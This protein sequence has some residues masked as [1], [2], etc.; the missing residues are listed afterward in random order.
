[1]KLIFIINN[2][3]V[4]SNSKRKVEYSYKN[5]I[6]MISL[7]SAIHKLTAS[8]IQNNQNKSDPI[9]TSFKP[10]FVH[11]VELYFKIFWVT[12]HTSNSP[13]RKNH[14]LLIANT[15]RHILA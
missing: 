2:V 8:A 10:D 4:V 7:Q 3:G 12:D 14:G 1:M 11:L 15:F 9:F 13:C 5:K 6:L